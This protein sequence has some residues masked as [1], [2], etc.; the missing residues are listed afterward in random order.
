MNI[1]G[2]IESAEKRYKQILEEFF[3]SVYPEKLLPSH[4]IDH[5]RRVWSYSKELLLAIRLEAPDKISSLPP[6]LIIACYL[7]DIGMSFDPGVKHGKNSRNLCVRFLIQNNLQETDYQNVLEAIE[8]HDNKNYDNKRPFDD[9]LTILSVSDDLDAFGFIGIFRYSDIYLRRGVGNGNIGSLIMENAKKRFDNFVNYFGA[10]DEFIQQHKTRY[11]ILDN[12]FS[13]YNEQLSSYH[14]GTTTPSG[15]CGVIEAFGYILKNNLQLKDFF[16]DQ[17]KYF[18]DPVI[19]WYFNELA[20]E[21]LIK[22][23]VL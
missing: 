3:V 18:D 14:F 6:E 23:T 16:I 20:S 7:H 22:H 10:V 11:K 21:L 13:K 2:S 15:F 4:G 19:R 17:K 1:T 12:F 9:L 8:Y 5:H